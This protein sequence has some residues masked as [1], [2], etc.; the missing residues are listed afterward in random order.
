MTQSVIACGRYRPGL[1]GSSKKVCVSFTF[2]KDLTYSRMMLA[3][4]GVPVKNAAKF[5]WKCRDVEDQTVDDE[6]AIP[7][8]IVAQV[9]QEAVQ[10]QRRL[11]QGTG[12]VV[13]EK[14]SSYL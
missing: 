5:A 9:T 10:E 7:Q 3:D 4:Q 1:G 8:F 2:W 13:T 12:D 14:T 11:F 6:P